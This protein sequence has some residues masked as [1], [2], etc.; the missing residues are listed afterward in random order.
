MSTTDKDIAEAVAATLAGKKKCAE[1]K[2]YFYPDAMASFAGSSSKP[3][4]VCWPCLHKPN[5]I[6][7]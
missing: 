4:Y 7:L 1:C 3:I 5:E 2:V 6:P